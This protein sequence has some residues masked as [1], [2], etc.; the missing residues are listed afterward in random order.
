VGDRQKYDYIF[1]AELKSDA[2]RWAEIDFARRW[3]PF[4]RAF[5]YILGN[6]LSAE[7]HKS[8]L[9]FDGECITPTQCRKR[10]R[11][12]QR[13]ASSTKLSTP[14]PTTPNCLSPH[15]PRK[16]PLAQS[17]QQLQLKPSTRRVKERRRGYAIVL[18]ALHSSQRSMASASEHRRR[19]KTMLQT[20]RIRQ[21]F[22]HGPTRRS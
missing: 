16:A 17:V 21:T 9:L 4:S 11:W 13:S 14:S 19:T 3:W 15:L 7:Q 1:S 2:I 10:S 20:Q 18:P 12:Q 5:Y 6:N 8:D 22:L